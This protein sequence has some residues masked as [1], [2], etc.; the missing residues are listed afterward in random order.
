MKKISVAWINQY[1]GYEHNFALQVLCQLLGKQ[2]EFSNPETCDLLFVGPFGHGKKSSRRKFARKYLSSKGLFYE[3]I[4][5][6][7][8]N[9]PLTIYQTGE[10]T[11]YNA[12]PTDYSISMDFSVRSDKHFRLPYWYSTMDWSHEGLPART[13][14]SFGKPIKKE[15]LMRPL[16]KSFMEKPRKA[17]LICRHLTEPR[18][19]L[20]ESVEKV[21]PV[22]GYGSA[23]S[24]EIQN[25]S[26]G[27]FTKSELLKNYGYSLC[28][29][30]SLY[31]GYYTEKIPEAFACAS[32]P[33]SWCDP[34]VSHD[35]NPEAFIN[36]H[37]F[38]AQGYDSVIEELL[39]PAKLKD[40]TTAPLLR[41]EPCLDGLRSFLEKIIAELA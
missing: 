10:N 34:H 7:R 3:Q 25:Y 4:L 17:A 13:T 14:P 2:I 18:K 1:K 12:V 9:K 29:E 16:D 41:Q 37:Q 36:M 33:I 6:K 19:S 26:C 40:Y 31:P 23:F 32:L 39:S 21:M 27:G 38:A 11:R 24:A 35:F 20:K 28:P 30:N 8:T 5:E 15:V 22:D